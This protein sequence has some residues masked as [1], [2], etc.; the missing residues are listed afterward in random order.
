VSEIDA[1]VVASAAD[2]VPLSKKT[3]RIT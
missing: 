1:S 3:C 2:G